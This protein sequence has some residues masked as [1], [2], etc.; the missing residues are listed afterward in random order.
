M[1]LVFIVSY[2]DPLIG[3]CLATLLIGT[4]LGRLLRDLT[5]HH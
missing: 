3:H 4:Y 5:T 1:S 2:P